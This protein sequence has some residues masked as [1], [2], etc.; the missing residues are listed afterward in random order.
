MM[1]SGREIGL[2]TLMEGMVMSISRPSSREKDQQLNG[3]VLDQGKRSLEG[4]QCGRAIAHTLLPEIESGGGKRGWWM[5]RVESKGGSVKRK[6]G[7]I[8]KW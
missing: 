3:R 7:K 2:V 5:R 6:K 1:H 4:K 8:R